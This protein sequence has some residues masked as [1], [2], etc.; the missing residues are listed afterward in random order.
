MNQ[1]FGGSINF[2]KLLEKVKEGHSAFSKSA[3]DGNVYFNFGL[4]VNDEP[5]EFGQH[6]SLNLN[7]SKEMKEKEGKVYFGNA[8][9][10][11][12]NQPVKNSDVNVDLSNVPVRQSANQNTITDNP[13]D[14]PF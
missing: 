13:D 10:I 14:L 9:K 8:K 1:F 3:K 11:E 5:N 12:T 2:S 6:C 4:W 7:S